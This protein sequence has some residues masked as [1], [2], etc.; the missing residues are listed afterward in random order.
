[1]REYRQPRGVKAAWRLGEDRAGRNERRALFGHALGIEVSRRGVTYINSAD[2]LFANG[3]RSSSSRRR[4]I[5]H[6]AS[7]KRARPMQK[8]RGATAAGA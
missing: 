5:L 4:F 1:M 2:A 6:Y 8:N 3:G 7:V